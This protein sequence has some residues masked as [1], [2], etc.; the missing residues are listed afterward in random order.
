M[1]IAARTVQGLGGGGINLL[2]ETVVTDIVPLRERGK[3]MSLVM[4]G[5]TLGA[6][7]GPFVGGA[8]TSSTTWRW[9]FYV[10]D[11]SGRPFTLPSRHILIICFCS[12]RSTFQSVAV[13]YPDHVAAI[14]PTNTDLVTFVSLWA[15]LRVNHQREQSWKKSLAR[16]DFAGNA[17]F[18]AAICAV[19]IALSWGGTLFEWSAY[20]IIV[21]LVLGFVG[22]ILFTAFEWTPK[23]CREPS[24]PRVLVS[25]RTSA[26]ALALTFIHAVVTYW[27][28]YFFPIYLQGVKQFSPLISG[29][30]TLPI[31]GG[32]LIFAL[33]GGA[34][35]SKTGRYKPI[36]LAGFVPLTIAFGL[37]SLLDFK[38]STAAWVCFELIWAIG[39]GLLVAILLPAMQAPLDESLVAT[40]TG[41]WSFM[42]YFGCIWGVTIPSAIFNNECRRL[43]FRVSDAAVAGKLTGGQAYQYATRAFLRGITDE[44]VRDEVVE[45]FSRALRTVWLIGIAFAGLGFLLTFLEKEVSLRDKLNT[46][47]G[48]ETEKEQPGDAKVVPSDGEITRTGSQER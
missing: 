22:L 24:M 44:S 46:D 30:G 1:L 18:V 42:R 13:S 37:F 43:A 12:G 6:S 35:L 8:I 36:H 28:Y 26:V 7:I 27:A 9:V 2:M 32:S 39:S 10:S 14:D 40:A 38:S 17:I 19:L 16:V 41:L 4:M 34:I 11:V 5:S 33:V 48:M 3:Y 15:C 23:L 31:F 25:N 47:F 20:N 29:V 21:P 45:V